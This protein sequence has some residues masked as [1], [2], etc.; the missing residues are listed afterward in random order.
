[1]FQVPGCIFVFYFF[2]FF[3]FGKQN[4][5]W[6]CARLHVL[7]ADPKIVVIVLQAGRTSISFVSRKP[8]FNGLDLRCNLLCFSFQFSTRKLRTV[9]NLIMTWLVCSVYLCF[10]RPPFTGLFFFVFFQN[11]SANKVVHFYC[12]T[13]A[14]LSQSWT[15]SACHFLCNDWLGPHF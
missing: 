8:K 1:M 3:S 13:S 10:S 5:Q 15:N 9:H 11:Y 12:P 6:G 7:I 2:L 14:T 4:V